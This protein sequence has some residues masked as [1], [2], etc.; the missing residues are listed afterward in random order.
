MRT[1]EVKVYTIDEHPD[2]ESVY[3]WIRANWH[4]LNSHSVDNLVASLE[5]LQKKIGGTL[6]YAISAVPDR[7]EFIRLSG[8]NPDA[9]SRLNS[10][11]CPLTGC[12]WDYHVIEGLRGFNPE[13]VLEVL[14]EDTE[15]TYSDEGLYHLCLANDYEFKES[16]EI[17]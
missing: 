14:H 1:I 13:R 6:D 10:E 2:R 9:L 17:Y 16:G 7:G 12:F 3:D 11:D 15:Y 8:Y 5:V 4:D